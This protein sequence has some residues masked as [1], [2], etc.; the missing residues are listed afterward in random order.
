MKTTAT[1]TKGEKA[2][3]NYTIE[4]LTKFLKILR[5]KLIFPKN[6]INKCQTEYVLQ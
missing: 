2:V 6:M 5:K 1:T 4:T 3:E